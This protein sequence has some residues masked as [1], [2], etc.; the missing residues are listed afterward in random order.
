MVSKFID[1]TKT[2]RLSKYLGGYTL[3]TKMDEEVADGECNPSKCEVLH[4]V[5]LNVR[6]N[7]TINGNILSSNGVQMDLGFQ[8]HSSL[9]AA[10]HADKMVKKI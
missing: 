5:R 2:G 9:K 3:A 6:G 4:Y 1:N 7:D 8:V 10:T